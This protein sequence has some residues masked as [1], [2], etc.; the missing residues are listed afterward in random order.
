VEQIELI[1]ELLARGYAYEANGS[2]YFSVPSF[3]DYGKLSHRRIEDQL[4]GARVG[5]DQDKRHPADFALWKKAEPQH[6]MRWTSPWG[7]GFPGWHA[8]CTA[9]A[10]KY[11]GQP[12]DIHGGGV[13]NLF[14]HNECEIAQAEAASGQPFAM[15]WLLAGTLTVGSVK[16]SKSLGNFVTL[17]EALQRWRPEAIRLFILSGHYRSRIDLTD[18]AL[19]AA[20]RGIV[21]LHGA[22]AIL[23]DRLRDAPDAGEMDPLWAEKLSEVRNRYAEAMDEDFNTAAAIGV[24][25]ELTRDVNGL[26]GSGDPVSRPTLAAID[27]AYRDLGET[28]LGLIPDPLSEQAGAGLEDAIRDRLAEIGV[29][30]EDGADGTRWRLNR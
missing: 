2:V 6:I 20:G 16:M 13:D 4:E 23:R 24:L 30:L 9:M 25:F 1:K 15:H 19:D 27:A 5:L 8:E 12:F 14:P 7:E 11:L 18:E 28:V 26:L 22:V 3:P 21:R 10:T 29:A 17:K